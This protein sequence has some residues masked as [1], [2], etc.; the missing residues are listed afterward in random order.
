MPQDP[1]SQR[2]S[3]LGK[4]VIGTKSSSR[5]QAGAS[6]M[7]IR[8]EEKGPVSTTRVMSKP[9]RDNNLATSGKSTSNVNSVVGGTKGQI[10]NTD[11]PSNEMSV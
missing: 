9:R 4:V 10:G 5:G 2:V 7:K 11:R 1:A 3:P 8:S 6:D